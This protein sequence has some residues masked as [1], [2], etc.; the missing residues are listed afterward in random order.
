MTNNTGRFRRDIRD[1]DVEEELWFRSDDECEE[2][3]GV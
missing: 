2:V 1:M 3:S